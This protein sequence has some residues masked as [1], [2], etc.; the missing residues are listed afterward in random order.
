MNI[1]RQKNIIFEADFE[2][3]R[4]ILLHPRN[5]SW[6]EKLSSTILR[7]LSGMETWSFAHVTSSRNN[8]ATRIAESVPRDNRT[9]W[10]NLM[11]LGGILF[12]LAMCLYTGEM[13]HIPYLLFF[14]MFSVVAP[15]RYQVELFVVF[16][17]F[18]CSK[19]LVLYTG[20][21]SCLFY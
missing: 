14:F 12:G 13:R 18:I 9:Q 6:L 5:F 20:F 16:G 1:T 7:L 10:P 21:L 11:L 15:Y 3:A 19:T 17:I 4:E 8:P 2:L